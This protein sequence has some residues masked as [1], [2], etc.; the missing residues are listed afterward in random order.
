LVNR[1]FILSGLIPNEYIGSRLKL[2]GQILKTIPS[3]H[4]DT[5]CTSTC[6]NCSSIIEVKL[7]EQSSVQQSNIEASSTSDATNVTFNDESPGETVEI[8]ADT[9][10]EMPYIPSNVHIAKFLNRPVL[11]K[12]YTW[13]L[14]STTV[15]SFDPWNLYFNHT[16]IKKKIDNYYLL[17][18]RLKV[19]FV[20]NASPFHY[21]CMLAA[22]KP[23][24]KFLTPAIIDDASTGSTDDFCNVGYS[25]LPR[26]YV[27]PQTSQGGELTLPFLWPKEW[28]DITT[29]SEL[30]NMGTFYLRPLT[31]LS[32]ANAGTGVN[33]NIQVFAWAEDVELSGPTVKLAMQSSNDEYGSISGPASAVAN[34]AGLLEEVPGI[35]LYAT[36][37]RMAATAVGSIAKIF[38][39]TNVP[40]ITDVHQFTPSPFPVFASPEIGTQIEKLTIDPKNELTIDPRSVGVDMGDELII[41]SIT[42]REAYLTQFTWTL[43]GAPDDILFSIQVSPFMERVATGTNQNLLQLVPMSLVAR[44]FSYWRG[45]IK[46][47][48][49]FVCSQ[50]H[51]GRLRVSWDPVGDI[52]A[53]ADSTTEVFT[54]IVD[55]ADCT[56]ITF[57][58]PYM[59][60]TAFLN[61]I[62]TYGQRFANSG[63]ITNSAGA[64][65]G[66]FTVRILNELSAPLSTADIKVL[67]FVAGGKNLEFASPTEIDQYY[68][69]NPVCALPAQ[70]AF[71]KYDT[72]ESSV[73]MG[74]APSNPPLTS[75]LT[76]HGEVVKSLRLL[77]RRTGLHYFMPL[78]S[79]VLTATSNGAIAYNRLSRYPYYPGSDNNGLFTCTK[80]ATGAG[81]INYVK[82]HPL[83]WIS[84]CYLGCRGAVNYRFNLNTKLDAVDF[85]AVRTTNNSST[86][87]S[88]STYRALN[89]TTTAASMAL[90]RP[91]L[92]DHTGMSLTNTKTNTGL[93]VSIPYYSKYK[94]RTTSSRYTTVGSS[95]DDSN[96]DWYQVN[97]ILNPA[98]DSN[99]ST[100][101]NN[102]GFEAFIGAG[103]DYSPIFFVN[104][105]TLYQYTS[106]PVS[107]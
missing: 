8:P 36:A 38:G 91:N 93:N 28:L 106:L 52:G 72:E 74:E 40:V 19:K 99:A 49:K 56:D 88:T 84:Q 1:Y 41:H 10:S 3:V 34:V 77:M 101:Y 90:S 24:S 92:I 97:T 45:D 2:L 50:Y 55:L 11:I 5:E 66:V 48:L 35:G 76:Y 15:D 83:T 26:V 71:Q 20:I 9:V 59:Q 29:A 70:S 42:D 73:E 89:T 85:N 39:F 68:A 32:F 30:T 6:C 14:G 86:T 51:K 60:T 63:S 7:P 17:R 95:S 61:S 107:T 78:N 18:C 16:S 102:I 98:A 94:F 82:W 44:M 87:L 37:T 43:A 21:G 4:T 96:L 54:Q 67:V 80:L 104:V 22:Y 46:I 64:T 79:N 81:R 65:N 31:A 58:I 100:T 23:L 12:N 33:C 47:R 75:Y 53:T 25:Q 105:P 57:N 103:T 62:F 13:S 27:Y 69:S